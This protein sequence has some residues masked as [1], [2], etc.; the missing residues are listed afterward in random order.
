MLGLFFLIIHNYGF[1]LIPINL[2]DIF[3][4]IKGDN[5]QLI[6][7]SQGIRIL[8][9]L[10]VTCFSMFLMRKIIISISRKISFH[11]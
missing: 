1:M 11:T 2:K 3:N 6:I 4:E 10:F 8:I 9:Y 7:K 5:N